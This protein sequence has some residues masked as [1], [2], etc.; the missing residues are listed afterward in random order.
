MVRRG[1]RLSKGENPAVHL[2]ARLAL[3]SGTAKSILGSMRV[4]KSSLTVFTPLEDGTAVLL[5]IGTRFYYSLNRTA[6]AVWQEIEKSNPSTIDDLVRITCERFDIDQ[7]AARR[8]VE[9]FIARLE[10]YKMVRV[11]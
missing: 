3:R 9:A 8:D 11:D 6:A 5:N 2:S 10:Q 4:E 1:Q 7:T